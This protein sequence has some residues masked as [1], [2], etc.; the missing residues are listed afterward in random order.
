[1]SKKRGVLE[2]RS[3]GTRFGKVERRKEHWH[4]SGRKNSSKGSRKT[5]SGMDWRQGEIRSGD[6]R[7]R[8]LLQGISALKGNG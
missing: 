6:Q 1:M 3:K 2:G 4:G 7:G 5:L 8:N